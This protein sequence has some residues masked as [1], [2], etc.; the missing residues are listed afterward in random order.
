MKRSSTL[1]SLTSPVTTIATHCLA[2]RPCCR[3][4]ACNPRACAPRVNYYTEFFCTGI[5]NIII[6]KFRAI[7]RTRKLASLATMIMQCYFITA[8]QPVLKRGSINKSLTFDIKL[9]FHIYQCVHLIH[10]TFLSICA[11]GLHS[12]AFHYLGYYVVLYTSAD[13]R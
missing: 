13:D 9:S 5:R 8:I 2:D 7:E 12:S 4:Y 3:F 10:A 11:E 1:G 6:A